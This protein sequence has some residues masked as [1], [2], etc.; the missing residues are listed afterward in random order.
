MTTFPIVAV[1]F[2]MNLIALIWVLT[3]LVLILII[4]I[5]KGRGGGLSSAFGGGSANSLLGTKTTDWLTKVTI[6]MV[7]LFLFLAVVMNKYYKPQLSE[8]LKEPAGVT[9]PMP[10]GGQPQQP[11]PPEPIQ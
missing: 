2:I 5:Q 3:A 6:A 9:S 4:L 10:E 7:M 8:E 1:S 11:R